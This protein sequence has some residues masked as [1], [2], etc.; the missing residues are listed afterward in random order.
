MMMTLDSRPRLSPTRWKA[1]SPYL[2][3]AMDLDDD[4]RAH[5][6]AELRREDPQ[7][8][9]DLE[10]LLDEQRTVIAEQ[11]LEHMDF[12]PPAAPS[13][14]GQ[15]L[16]AWRLVEAIGQGGM[17]TVWRAERA[18]G[19]FEGQAAVKL[20][21]LSLMGDASPS[22]AEERFRRE[23]SLLAR[24]NHEHIAR[25]LDAG[26]SPTGQ[27]YLVL[28]HIDGLPIDRYCDEH[29]LGVEARIR[30][31][32]DVLD[33]V[34][35]AHANLVVHRDLK[36]SNVLVS[37]DGR[38][39]LLDFGIAKLLESEAWAVLTHDGVSVLTPEFAAPEQVTRRPVTTATDVY[40]LGVLLYVLLGGHHPAGEA[41]N[42]PAELVRSIVDT[43]PKRM[44]DAVVD[45]SPSDAPETQFRNAARRGTTPERL[46]RLLQGDLDTI[47]AKALR[48]S[49]EDRYPSVSALAD[50]L[51]R[52]LAHEPIGARPDAIAY[53]LAK[54]VR[55]HAVGVLV[56]VGTIALLAGFGV[57]HTARLTAERD[58][59]TAEAQKSAKVSQ[60]LTDFLASADPFRDKPNPTMLDLLDS[61]AI[62]L[63]TELAS[64]PA[65][66]GELLTAIGR[67]YTRLEFNDKAKVT[68]ER[69]LALIRSAG[70]PEHPRLGQA[71]NDLGVLRREMGDAKASVELLKEALAVRRRLLGPRHK[72][73]GVTLSELGRSYDDLDDSRNAEAYA[74]EALAMRRSVF[75][76]EHRE[77]AT[78]LGDL[79][80]Y[81]LKRGDL[82]GA[83]RL[84][85][86]S[87][88]ISRRILGPRHPNVGASMG[89]VGRVLAEKGDF[90]AAEPLFREALSIKREVM[91]PKNP[92]VAVPLNTLA[93]ALRE[94]GK[95]AEAQTALEEAI[96][97][98][99][100]TN[101]PDGRTLA[102]YRTSLARVHLAK[103]EAAV[104]VPLLVQAL[105]VRTR[106]FGRDDWR[107]ATT[108][109]VL[110]EAFTALRRYEEAEAMLLEARRVLKP[111]PGQ[112]GREAAAA[113]ARLTKL[114]EV[115]PGRGAPA[116]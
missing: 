62:R 16:G 69:A 67:V 90:A 112:E 25:L 47:V 23:G 15:T 83:E 116:G 82:V 4:A 56:G 3:R 48:K 33:A 12:G 32:L 20:L 97:I 45:D 65:T 106:V 50:D 58:R 70:G 52:F 35:H 89:N 28:E 108:R 1:V 94:Q 60:V 99:L 104:A 22:H 9:D 11:F 113:A 105:E 30:L 37:S 6:Q 7:L 114:Y 53:R 77:I 107:V 92:S 95:L 21:N 102:Q 61:G 49:S 10:Q 103:G 2:D 88:E 101:E 36:P 78:N 55:R 84:L 42:S 19:R 59:A 17:G 86:Q 100:P 76:E 54:F 31:F 27:P 110:G 51:N 73:L 13:L 87:Y 41:F 85:R 91:G 18:D 80:Q 5:F 98:T 64:E 39:K 79:G 34:A 66:L 43:N 63:Q 74:W 24:L 57:Y 14:A 111:N 40:S 26:V 38:V 72:D 93:W 81:L 46:R 71:L 29:R 109:S 75:G 68:L 44:S 8:A 115:W 96:A